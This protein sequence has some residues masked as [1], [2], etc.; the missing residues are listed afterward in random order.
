MAKYMTRK[1]IAIDQPRIDRNPYRQYLVP[2]PHVEITPAIRR[3]VR[4]YI[5]KNSASPQETVAEI[6]EYVRDLPV[7]VSRV[8][9]TT[10][11]WD[12]VPQP[13]IGIS[14][15]TLQVG[16]CRSVGVATR[17]QTWKIKPSRDLMNR[18]NDFSVPRGIP[19]I[20]DELVFYHSS[21]EVFIK[22]RW[23]VVDATIDRA[24]EPV[25]EANIWSGVKDIPIK[26]FNILKKLGPSVDVPD[27]A[28]DH[29]DWGGRL[30]FYLR[31][32][33][34]LSISAHTR[35][36]HRLLDEIRNDGDK[37]EIYGS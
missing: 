24:L 10:L 36:I 23:V 35:R 17:F 9:P 6:F 16:L 3:M 1:T 2:S 30:P 12:Q 11:A 37:E 31:P 33:N 25:F 14:K 5:V 29:L 21:A 22:D 20:G 15:A 4:E 34:G 7:G 26:G 18:I 19:S 32:F 28:V 27:V 8:Y 13:L